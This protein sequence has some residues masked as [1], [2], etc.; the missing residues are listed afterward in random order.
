MNQQFLFVRMLDATFRDD[1]WKG[2]G[3]DFEMAMEVQFDSYANPY[4]SFSPANFYQITYL[5]LLWT[6]SLFRS[7]VIIMDDPPTR[8]FSRTSTL[9]L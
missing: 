1:I 4:G 7:N 5:I 3:F 8:F 6:H 2:L 9:H